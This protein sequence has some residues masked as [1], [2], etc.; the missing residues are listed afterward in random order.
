[1]LGPLPSSPSQKPLKFGI[2]GAAK[3]AP[4]ALIN[5]A[6]SHPEVVVYAVAARNKDR[7]ETFAKK[8]GIEKAYGS[9]DELINDPEVDVVYNPVSWNSDF[10]LVCGSMEKN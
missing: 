1:M 5:P 2:L 9:Y 7:A 4:F 6:R 8:H 3:I 10:F